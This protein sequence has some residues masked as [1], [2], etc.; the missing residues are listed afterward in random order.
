MDREVLTQSVR[1]TQPYID[2]VWSK[3]LP[4]IHRVLAAPHSWEEVLNSYAA[5]SRVGVIRDPDRTVLA[6]WGQVPHPEDPE[7]CGLWIMLT[8]HM[9]KRALWF[10]RNAK[11]LIEYGIG[12]YPNALV[13]Y[14][15]SEKD[16][17][18]WL[19]RGGFKHYRDWVQNGEL[20]TEYHLER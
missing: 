7:W 13:R 9:K 19:E 1:V 12:D 17:T 10:Y 5:S 8:K 16:L 6:L 3:E 15:K 4:R 2:R 14:R 11:E 18:S 20:W